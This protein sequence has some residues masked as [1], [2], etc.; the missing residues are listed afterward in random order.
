MSTEIPPRSAASGRRFWLTT[1]C[2]L[3]LNCI[4]WVVYDHTYALRHRGVLRV[5]SFDP[6][7]T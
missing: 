4:A 3:I 2:F 1:L 6:G 5:E 7:D